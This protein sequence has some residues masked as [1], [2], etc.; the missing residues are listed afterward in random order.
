MRL[1]AR[2]TS[3]L[4]VIS[5]I[6]RAPGFLIPVLV[7]AVFGAG[8]QTDAY[9]IAYGAV[10]LI[11]GTL[12]QGVE[13]SIV[14]FA[15]REMLGSEGNAP[16]FL[17]SIALKVMAAGLAL[18]VLTFP[19]LFFVS[20]ASLRVGVIRYAACFTLLVVMWGWAAVYAGASVSRGRIGTATGSMLW[21][22][23]G[24]LLGLALA[25]IGAGLW[26]VGLGLGIGE[27]CRAVWLRSQVLRSPRG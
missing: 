9:F 24:G 21:R 10:L 27:L 17:R 6:G 11:G 23:A 25:P 18:W 15:A 8:S 26:G 1:S 16:A 12:A 20:G 19:V 22:G 14:P 7:A 3:L 4:A 13:V 5:V 2:R